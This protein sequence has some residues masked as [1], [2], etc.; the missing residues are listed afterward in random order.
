[1]VGTF[2]KWRPPGKNTSGRWLSRT[3][4]SLARP[5]GCNAVAGQQRCELRVT[6]AESLPGFAPRPAGTDFQYLVRQALAG[7]R[8]EQALVA[9]QLEGVAGE[10]FGPQIAVVAGRVAAVEQVAEAHQVA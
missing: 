7:C 5:S 1:M 9:K 8:V 6:A 4:Q 10:L 2:W 3:E